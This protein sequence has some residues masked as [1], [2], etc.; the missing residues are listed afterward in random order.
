MFYTN[1]A[2]LGNKMLIREIR[3]GIRKDRKEEFHPTFYM[4]T[5]LAEP[6]FSSLEGES[7][8]SYQPGT[9]SDCRDFLNQ[10]NGVDGYKVYG[11]THYQSQ[12]ISDYYGKND[13]EYDTSMI[14]IC[15][16]DI[17]VA[18]PPN[19]GFP[20]PE[21]AEGEITA[22]TIYDNIAK[23]YFIWSLGNWSVAE[24]ELDFITDDNCT[25]VYCPQEL[26]LI[27]RF[28]THMGA[29]VYD[30]ITG[31]YIELFDIPY[32]I[33][34]IRAIAGEKVV[35]QLSPWGKIN[36]RTHRGNFGQET[37]TYEL[38]GTST[39]DYLALYKKFTYSAQE[40]Y[41]LDYIA[42]AEVGARKLDYSE[43]SALFNLIQSPDLYH[44]AANKDPAKLAEFQR[45]VRMRDMIQAE[46]ER[47]NGT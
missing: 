5:Q 20:D 21:A 33:N 6:D 27:T 17:E 2:R 8:Q 18:T 37:T 35:K 29:S 11:Y 39:L 31:W 28:A 34:R 23:H 32:L 47:R 38:L 42:N 14:R 7:L 46:K 30:V 44:V 41:T 22:I 9:M 24:T 45:W 26:D 25:F 12:W 19:G 4:S 10:Y 43:A 36:K 3:D 40:S 13:I 15:N 16:I 1:I